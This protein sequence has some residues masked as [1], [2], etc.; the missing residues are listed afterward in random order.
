[1]KFFI[2]GVY[3]EP[4]AI[5]FSKL[6]F[7]PF[8]VAIFNIYVKLKKPF[9]SEMLRFQFQWPTGYA[10]SH[11][12]FLPKIVLPLFLTGVLNFCVKHKNVFISETV[13]NT[14]ISA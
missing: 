2:S 1:M 6:G 9:I 13:W 3:A 10:Q 11:S 7:L 8:F 4:F 14:V 12:P 5:F